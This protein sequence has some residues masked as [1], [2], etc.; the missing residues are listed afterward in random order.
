MDNVLDIE[1]LN[2]T[3]I[4]YGVY[5]SVRDGYAWE[6]ETVGAYDKE[7]AIF[8]LFIFFSDMYC[9]ISAVLVE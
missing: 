4:E 6:K 3:C 7:T 9:Q 1:S 8:C 5:E 2:L